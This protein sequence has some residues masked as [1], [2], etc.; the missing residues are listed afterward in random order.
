MAV[1]PTTGRP[2]DIGASSPTDRTRPRS[3]VA[4]QEGVIRCSVSPSD[5]GWWQSR[6]S[7]GEEGQPAWLSLD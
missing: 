7:H 6:Y 2:D 4:W 5:G 1:P 3:R